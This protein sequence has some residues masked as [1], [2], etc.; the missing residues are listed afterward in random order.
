MIKERT[1]DFNGMTKDVSKNKD[2]KR[3]YDARNIRI[4]A[5]DQESA[6]AITN[7]FGTELIFSIP[8]PEFSYSD[9]EISYTVSGEEKTLSYTADTA[10]VP[11]CQLEEEY[12]T[13]LGT[14][15]TN[16]T[17]GTQQ[18]IGVRELRDSAL[19]VTT[20]D[21]GWDCVWELTGLN[22]EDF[23]LDLLYM[24][25]LGLSSDNLMNILFNYENS[26][27]QKVYLVDGDNQ[28]RYINIR[29]SVE[30]G[31]SL[32]LIDLPPTSMDVVGTFDLSQ[33]SIDTIFSGGS[34]TTGMIQYA[35]SLYI[36]NGAQTVTSPLSELT[37]IDKGE[38]L[39]GGE[40]NENL[41]KSITISIPNVD[42]NFTHVKLYSI[43]YTSYNEIPD[44]QLIADQE[45]DSSGTLSYTDTG[46]DGTTLTLEEFIFLGATP[47]VPQS[48]STKDNTLFAFNVKEQLFEVDLDTRAYSYNSSSAAV[49][50]ENVSYDDYG[51]LESSTFTVPSTF[52][53]PTKHDSINADYDTYK[54]Q[55]DGSTLGATGKYIEVEILQTS[56]TDDEA[57][58]L[59]FFKDNEFYRIGVK[60]FNR[61]GQYTNAAWIMDLRAP[62]GNLAGNYSQLKVTL[63]DE[64]NTWLSDEDNFNSDDDKPIGYR[65]IRADRQ[66]SDRT[67]LTQGMI[68]PMIASYWQGEKTV[69]LSAVKEL[70]N[71]NESRKMPSLTRMFTGLTPVLG[72][73]D[74]HDLAFVSID[75]S[76]NSD[77]NWNYYTEGVKAAD[78][79]DWR[80]QNF[81]FNRLMQMFSPEVTFLDLQ[82]DSGYKLKIR[83]LYEYDE[84]SN[85]TAETNPLTDINEVQVLFNNGFNQATPGVNPLVTEGSASDPM[86][87][88]FFG[89]TNGDD[90]RATHQVY[91]SF[92]GDFHEA[93][94]V[95]EFDIFGTPEVTE[96]GADYT[97]Y[98]NH[99]E[100]RYCNHLKTM[101]I[102][103]F[104]E[105]D[106][107]NNDAKVQIKGCNTNGARCI[108]F[109]EGKDD[110][111]F[112]VSYR[113]SIEDIHQQSGISEKNGVLV[114]EFK[115]DDS[116]YYA[117]GIYG[118]NTYEAKSNTVYLEIG[119]YTDIETNEVTIESPG[120]TFVSVFTFTKMSTDDAAI[121]TVDYNLVTEIVSI[122]TETTID[123]KNRNDL[124]ISEWNNVWIPSYDEYQKYNT[125][126]SQQPTLVKSTSESYKLKKVQEFDTRI[127]ATGVKTP[128]EFVDSWTD[129]LE[130]EEMD[131][132]GKYGPINTI[133]NYRDNIYAIQ[134]NA[135]ALIQINP[136]VQVSAS[137]GLAVEMGTGDLLY[138][139][140]YLTTT[141]GC[142]N[143]NGVVSTPI[144]FYF[145]DILNNSI[146]YCNGQT[147]INLSDKEG[148]HSDLIKNMN[149]T[150]LKEDNPV[151]GYGLSLA[152]NSSTGDVL[153]SF[154]QSENSFTLCYSEKAG[155]FVSYYDYIPA[156]YINKG[157]AMLSTNSDNTQ[158]WQHFKGEKNS[159]YGKT[160]RS[161]ITLHLVAEKKE[162]V[163]NGASYRL[164]MEDADGNILANEGLTS[165]KVW[166]K[167][168]ESDEADL[169]LRKNAFKRIRDWNIKFPRVSGSRERVRGSWGYAEFIFDN[170][171][172]KK[173]ILH[174]ITIF[175][176]E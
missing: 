53:V 64:F 135:V 154:T 31:D 55:S 112:D 174:D 8:T 163:M 68:N 29:Q 15:Y 164:E 49:V 141:S 39:G 148:F 104:N 158:L 144:G 105:S 77:L 137:D 51:N 3:Y 78:S 146:L 11:R 147:V 142:L 47:V 56:M 99:G 122:K 9:T 95:T 131:L 71:S 136:R 157:T 14:N 82:I 170:D 44:I 96:V 61:R 59:Q 18:I 92:Q 114:A 54:Y 107:A 70:V 66:L 65:I 36:L 60:F 50:M 101:L 140:N 48:I 7:E 156:W 176:T 113:K 123:L 27:I 32:N 108:T 43:K 52:V 128:G 129:F 133:I 63:T 91:Q 98:N 103:D 162:L 34:H 160:F 37:S 89:P 72:C 125:V 139:Y 73:K 74:Y 130:N 149:Y 111:D 6:Y 169:V 83:G 10:T 88:G 175:Y 40:V 115:R 120:D 86:D 21:N 30:N 19:I 17:S 117:G 2:S 5:T 121:T 24:N 97:T 38:D 106:A 166:N 138:N 16:K 134:D 124:S 90:T 69:G 167:Y 172:G 58:E 41:G 23:D 62:E 118:G 100:L 22:D 1:F 119:E 165:V 87:F 42:S 109:A 159:F 155:A 46:V 132:D 151:K 57:E 79:D 171:D 150:E 161:S 26:I 25:N 20:D 116:V 145:V 173:L 93:T 13:V 76:Q 94:G 127:I 45:I 28:I 168:Q 33:V 35:Y 102:D 126:Y 110:A 67:I 75:S 84:I 4:L 152:Y 143:A 81:Q 85:W 153:F 80:A 12:V